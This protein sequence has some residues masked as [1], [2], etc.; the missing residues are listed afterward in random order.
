[1]VKYFYLTIERSISVRGISCT[2]YVSCGL[3]ILCFYFL[4]F[5]LVVVINS[6]FSRD[7]F[8]FPYVILFLL[9]LVPI[10]I[11]FPFPLWA[12]GG[13]TELIYSW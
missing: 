2:L 11:P 1:M 12:G 10:P 4:F 7:C 9:F 3:L 13:V 5:P 8:G 6:R